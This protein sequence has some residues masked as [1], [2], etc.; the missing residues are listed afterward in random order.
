MVAVLIDAYVDLVFEH[1]GAEDILLFREDMARTS[2]ALGLVM[3]WCAGRAELVL[4]AVP[5]PI[6]DYG[7]LDVADFMVSLYNDHS[8]Q[9]LM[10]GRLDGKR[11]DAMD[12][13]GEALEVLSPNAP[14]LVAPVRR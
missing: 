3:D 13:F 2:P 5:V 14:R 10:L 9:R 12:V 1:S 6:A 7:S 4:E 11:R 8:V